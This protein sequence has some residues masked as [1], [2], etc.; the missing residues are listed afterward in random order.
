MEHQICG[1]LTP[2][3][4]TRPFVEMMHD[5]KR[6]RRLLKHLRT[7]EAVM[8]AIGTGVPGSQ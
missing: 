5:L 6:V 1:P 7:E 3:E 4:R 8:G 2:L